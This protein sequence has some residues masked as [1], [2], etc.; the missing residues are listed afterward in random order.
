[1][2]HALP[3]LEPRAEQPVQFV[4]E[5]GGIYF[6]A[7]C[8]ERAGDVVPQHSH[9]HDHV[10][11]IASGRARVWCDGIWLGD[12]AAFHALEIKAHA[13]HVFLALEPLT[14]LAC[15]HNLHGAAYRIAEEHE[16]E[17]G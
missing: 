3:K 5:V 11:L 7:I 9:E 16:L 10:T 6:R 2:S 1:M 14:R 4:D 8:L 17:M 15:V 12:F 13:K